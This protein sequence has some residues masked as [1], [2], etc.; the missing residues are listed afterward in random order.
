MGR[1]IEVVAGFATNP[2]ATFTQLTASTGQSFT[3]RGTDITKPT[4]LFDTWAFNAVAGELRI[5]APRL[6]DFF[7]G[8]RNRVTAASTPNLFLDPTG[9]SY[10]QR[11]CPPAALPVGP[12]RAA[13]EP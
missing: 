4:W 13:P 5:R 12:T 6:H 1:A 9:A 2:G 7:S 11:R 3:V 10:A 8:I